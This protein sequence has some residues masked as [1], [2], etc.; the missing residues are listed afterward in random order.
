MLIG[1]VVFLS[2]RLRAAELH[3]ISQLGGSRFTVASYLATEIGLQLITATALAVSGAIVTQLLI[4]E[5]CNN[6]C[7]NV[8]SD[9][10]WDLMKCLAW[11]TVANG[12][13]LQH[14]HENRSF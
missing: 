10:R 7:S 13:E 3:T 11:L 1:L 4:A 12:E 8:T 9:K 2:I 14:E 5:S 6:C